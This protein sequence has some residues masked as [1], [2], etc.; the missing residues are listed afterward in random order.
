MCRI[1]DHPC[2]KRGL[3]NALGLPGARVNANN[4]RSAVGKSVVGG[5]SLRP[6]LDLDPFTSPPGWWYL[7]PR[8]SRY[9]VIRWV[10]FPGC[11]PQGTPVCN[12]VKIQISRTRAPRSTVFTGS[13]KYIKKKMCA[14]YGTVPA[15]NGAY[16]LTGVMRGHPGGHSGVILD[17][18]GLCCLISR[19]LYMGSLWGHPK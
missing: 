19:S 3:A 15:T 5:P 8:S 6:C 1:W 18:E 11:V 14:K 17:P 4:M 2:H 10:K 13:C 16:A 12:G 9:L 7:R